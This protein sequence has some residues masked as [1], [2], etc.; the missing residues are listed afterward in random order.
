MFSYIIAIECYEAYIGEG[1]MVF[2]YVFIFV[3]NIWC[4]VSLFQVYAH[5]SSKVRITSKAEVMRL[6]DEGKLP[7]E[8]TNDGDCNDTSNKDNV[9]ISMLKYSTFK[10]ITLWLY[11]IC[12][13][14]LKN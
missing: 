7:D 4:I 13:N 10:Y 5:P 12:F 9:W 6:I 2:L 8:S 11:I 1:A 3:H 14:I